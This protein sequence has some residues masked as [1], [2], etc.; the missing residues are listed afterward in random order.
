M[1]CSIAAMVELLASSLPLALYHHLSLNFAVISPWIPL[2][3][4]CQSHITL[5]P[6]FTQLSKSYHLGSHFHSKSY[7]HGSHF[8]SKSYH[9]GFHFHSAVQSH[10]T[11][12]PTFTQSHIT[13]DPT[14]TQLCK[15]IS[16]WIPLS[17]KVISPWIPLSLKHV[18][19]KTQHTNYAPGYHNNYRLFCPLYRTGSDRSA[20]VQC[21]QQLFLWIHCS[22]DG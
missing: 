20:S 15:V 4:S 16:P 5:D 12:D 19:T 3:L 11:M 1:T 9:H 8:Q 13:V 2:S 6:T 14:F 10:I 17:L 7:H 22:H 18:V 21:E